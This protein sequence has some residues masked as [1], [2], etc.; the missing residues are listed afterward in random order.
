M[1]LK[2]R[3]YYAIHGEHV[4]DDIVYYFFPQPN[5]NYVFGAILY[6]YDMKEAMKQISL[7]WRARK[8]G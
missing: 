8:T 1:E 4:D 2:F 7:E 5:C 6:A 3:Q